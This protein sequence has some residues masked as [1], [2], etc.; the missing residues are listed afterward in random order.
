MRILISDRFPQ[1]AAFLSAIPIFSCLLSGMLYF[2][3]ILG[4]GL[5]GKNLTPLAAEALIVVL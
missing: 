3:N 5:S 2:A 4:S 1:F